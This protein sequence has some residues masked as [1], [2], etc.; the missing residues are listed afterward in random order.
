MVLANAVK[1]NKILN[2]NNKYHAYLLDSIDKASKAL[3]LFEL[4]R[5]KNFTTGAIKK[6]N[7]LEE[8]LLAFVI[9]KIH[10][11]FDTSRDAVCLENFLRNNTQDITFSSLDSDRQKIMNIFTN[12]KKDHSL[13]IEQIKNNRHNGVA[14]IPSKTKLGVIEEVAVKIRNLGKRTGNNDYINLKSVSPEKMIFAVGNFPVDEA[15]KLTKKLLDLIF[16]IKYPKTLD[17]KFN[18]T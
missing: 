1:E 2:M 5:G 12:I 13:I 14:H 8:I 6:D 15:K 9:L 4:L 17:R 10:T 7:W 3:D 18:E 16:G 11:I